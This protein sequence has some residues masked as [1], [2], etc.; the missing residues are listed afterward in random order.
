MQKDISSAHPLFL[1]F[2]SF[3]EHFLSCK[4]NHTFKYILNDWKNPTT[5]GNRFKINTINVSCSFVAAGSYKDLE[6]NIK[7]LEALTLNYLKS[8]RLAKR[9]VNFFLPSKL[10]NIC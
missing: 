3:S 4:K 10:L 9:N 7:I 5:N 6:R 1:Y 2:F 8:G